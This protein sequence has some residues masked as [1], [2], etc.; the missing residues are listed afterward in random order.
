ML[1]GTSISEIKTFSGHDIQN[2]NEHEC[3]FDMLQVTLDI[4]TKKN[5]TSEVIGIQSFR[6]LLLFSQV[7]IWLM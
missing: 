5:Y 6:I 7:W 3:A 2:E 1:Q 4:C